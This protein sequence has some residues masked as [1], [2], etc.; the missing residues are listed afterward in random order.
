LEE[1][2]ISKKSGLIVLVMLALLLSA[3]QR[4]ESTPPAPAPTDDITALQQP[5]ATE[6]GMAV[7]EQ[8]ITQTAIAALGTQ[9]PVIN[10][11]TATTPNPQDNPQ[12]VTPTPGGPVNA[13]T[14]LP[15]PTIDPNAPAPNTPEPPAPGTR[16]TSYTLKEGEF[17]F[18]LARRFDLDPDQILALNGLVDSETIYPGLTLNLPTTGS[19]PGPRA[20]KAH[21]ATYTVQVNDTIYSV[22][23]QY[24]DVRP[25]QIANANNLVAPFDL[26]VGAQ[27]QI[28]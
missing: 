12:I 9:A 24:G 22:A 16:P 26:T 2:K 11:G 21:P 18:C 14:A 1:K 5:Q 23:C 3:C 8:A 4:S 27:I 20:L 13:D 15:S 7:I 6:A 10:D 17:V 25:N 19:F 28:P